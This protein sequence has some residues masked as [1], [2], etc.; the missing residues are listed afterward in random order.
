M[1]PGLKGAGDDTDDG[2]AEPIDTIR[3]YGRARA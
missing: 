3:E 2:G 1:L